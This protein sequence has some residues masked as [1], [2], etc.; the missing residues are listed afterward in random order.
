MKVSSF[1][2]SDLDPDLPADLFILAV[3]CSD[4]FLRLLWFDK[5]NCRFGDVAKSNFH[6]SCVLQLIHVISQSNTANQ[7][8][9]LNDKSASHSSAIILS[10][11][12]DGRIC[13][14]DV[15]A[16]VKSFCQKY[17]RLNIESESENSSSLN[18]AAEE[19]KSFSSLT[20]T[21]REQCYLQKTECDDTLVM[22]HNTV[23]ENAGVTEASERLASIQKSCSSSASS[24]QT[25]ACDRQLLSSTGGS[26]EVADR[27]V[28]NCE[29]RA[30]QGSELNPCCVIAAHQSGVNSLAVHQRLTGTLA[31]FTFR[32]VSNCQIHLTASTN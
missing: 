17:R 1:S 24:E 28:E 26:C 20:E 15:T 25:D 6:G 9:M 29:A 8:S 12:T 31:S 11:G 16:L 2:A 27:Q 13:V 32:N 23:A 30:R 4:S 21:V 10:A 22:F 19:D 14:W 3:A 5:S 18:Q 7:S